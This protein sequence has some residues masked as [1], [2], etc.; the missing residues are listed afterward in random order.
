MQFK[1]WAGRRDRLALALVGVIVL[2]AGLSLMSLLSESIRGTVTRSYEQTWR[3]PYDILVHVPLPG[4]AQVADI[5][6]PNL[7]TTLPPGITKAQWETVKAVSGVEI[8]APLAVLGQL[9]ASVYMTMGFGKSSAPKEYDLNSP[10]PGVYR[11]SSRLASAD[12]TVPETVSWTK[13]VAFPDF[14]NGGKLPDYM[15]PDALKLD[16]KPVTNLGIHADV[17]VM[18]VGLDPA[19]EARLAGLEGAL[20]KGRYLRSDESASPG[21]HPITEKDGTVIRPLSLPVLLNQYAFRGWSFTVTVEELDEHLQVK[22]LVEERRWA[23]PELAPFL[24]QGVNAF[25]AIRGQSGPLLYDMVASPFP[26]R[27]PVALALSPTQADPYGFLRTAGLEIDLGHSFRAWT[28]LRQS[29]EFDVAGLFDSAKLSVV[30]EPASHMP[31]MTYRPAEALHVLDAAGKPVNPPA[32]VAGGISPVGFLSSPPVMVTTIPAAMAVA[33]DGAINAVQVKVAGAEH[34]TPETVAKVRAVADEI[35]RKTGLVAEVVM[36]S[37]PVNVLIKVPA[38]GGK[39]DYGWV[40]ETWIHKNAAT[41]AVQQTEF[42]YSLYIAL[43]IAVALLYALATGLAGVTARR[44]ELGVAAAVGWPGRALGRIAAAEQMLFALVAG[45]LAALVAAVGGAPPRTVGLTLLAGLLVYV[46]AAAAAWVAAAQV[47]PGDALRWGDT[48][49]GRRVLPGTGALPLALA[50]LMGRPGRTLLTMVA[51]ALPTALLLVLAFISRHLSGVLFTT[52]TGQY[53][54]MKAGP[55]QYMAGLIAL[56]IAAMTAFDLVRQNAADHRQER[57]LLH[58]LGWPRFRIVLTMVAEG[59]VLGAVAGIIG[60]GVGVGLIALLYGRAV[61]AIWQT[62]LLVA[63]LPLGLGLVTGLLSSVAE[64]R[65]WNRQSLAGVSER[66]VARFGQ[67]TWLTAGALL[68]LAAVAL[69]ALALPP[70]LRQM[71]ARPATAPDLAARTVADI[72]EAVAAQSKAM[73]QL[74]STAFLATLDPAES[75]YVMEQ[76]HWLE[77]AAVWRKT[78]PDSPLGREAGEVHLLGDNTARVQ[79]RQDPGGSIDT[80]WI[81][82]ADG[83]WLEHGRDHAV[84]TDGP[85]TVWYPA[86]METDR[87]RAFA[88]ETQKSLQRLGQA[89]WIISTPVTIELPANRSELRRSLG[90]DLAT[91]DDIFYFWSEYG[92]PLRLP[93]DRPPTPSMMTRVLAY[94]SVRQMSHNQAAEWLPEGLARYAISQTTG[95]Y[96]PAAVTAILPLA[97]LTESHPL[98]DHKDPESVVDTVWLLAEYLTEHDGPDAVTRVLAAMAAA[99]PD[100]PQMTGPATFATRDRATIA[101]FEQATGRTWAELDRELQAWFQARA[102]R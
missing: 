57:A 5:T 79:I 78:H 89:G 96:K 4:G 60:T 42:G 15:P 39:P 34:F 33:G 46:P 71:K 19:A 51:A 27:W 44:R 20:V 94:E 35:Q 38:A 53:A 63:L 18:L 62:A 21:L 25:G 49:P 92:E 24:Q 99:A 30:M 97:R 98:Y 37:S 11:V 86:L 76:R 52:V 45:L 65:S 8:A 61:T 87:V 66:Q 9:Q 95:E 83:R 36:G 68:V 13:T 32:T 40:E 64:L 81:K 48:A 67:K 23:G 88:S 73:Q 47:S 55:L 72:R 50:S 28:P 69:G 43:V 6:E 91:R 10:G 58:A 59:G 2:G 26:D 102:G 82:N 31:L 41:T 17:P 70:A 90:P 14:R 77:N 16:G 93:A 74:D 84:L 80:I 1:F 54:A 101:A 12:S 22:R 29:V 75:A 7:L 3:A 56:A 85:V 100:D